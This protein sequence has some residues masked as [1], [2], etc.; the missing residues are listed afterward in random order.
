V[1]AKERALAELNGED[2]AIARWKRVA[3]LWCARWFGGDDAAP[4]ALFTDLAE[5]ILTGRS[6]IAANVRDRFLRQTARVSA[7]R[8]FF[9]WELEFP[10]VFFDAAGTQ[11]ADAGF[12]AV[13]GNP[14]WDMV[15]GDAAEAREEAR[16]LA[17]ATV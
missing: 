17:A 7:E 6:V 8:R 15:R 4:P 10:E 11:R 3:D 5:A 12:D 1:R 16:R 13:L 2:A 9:H 14:P